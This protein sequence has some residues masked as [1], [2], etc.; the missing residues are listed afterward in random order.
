M[1]LHEATN[2]AGA[3]GQSAAR[4]IRQEAQLAHHLLHF[5]LRPLFE[6]HELLAQLQETL[7]VPDALVA[8]KDLPNVQ[9]LVPG[10]VAGLGLL[11]GNLG[12]LL[13][14]WAGARGDKLGLS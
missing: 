5:V 7:A 1:P 10:G 3:G 2:E 8:V 11:R 14:G 12:G 4:A 6:R 13:L 9:L